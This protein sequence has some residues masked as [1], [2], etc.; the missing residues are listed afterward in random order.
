MQ[1]TFGIALALVNARNG[2]LLIDEFENGLHY[3][4]QPD[5]WRLIFQVARRLNV[6]VFMM[7]PFVKTVFGQK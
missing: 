4:V 5:L 2:L 3:L 7:V 6:Q 1:R